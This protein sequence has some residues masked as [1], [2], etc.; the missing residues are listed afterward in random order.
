MFDMPWFS[1]NQTKRK[2]IHHDIPGKLWEVI[3][4]AMFTFNNKNY[5]S[6][7]DYDSKFLVIKKD[8]KPVHRQLNTSK[9]NYFFQN[10]VCQRK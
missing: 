1:E 5:L 7:V 2:F 3:G 6:I 4:V 10:M 9:Q 8:Q